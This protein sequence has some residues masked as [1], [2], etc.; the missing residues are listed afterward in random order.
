MRWEEREIP[1]REGDLMTTEP[2]PP[3]GD[4]MPGAPDPDPAPVP[5]DPIPSEPGGPGSE[6][7]VVPSGEPEPEVRP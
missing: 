1:H 2:V 6:P 3:P 5:T 7:D 4:P